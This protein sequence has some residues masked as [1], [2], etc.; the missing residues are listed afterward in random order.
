MAPPPL[1][2]P[3]R[4]SLTGEELLHAVC[5]SSRLA[6]SLNRQELARH[7]VRQPRPPLLHPDP[8]HA[9]YSAADLD[10]LRPRVPAV[11]LLP[12]ER[13]ASTFV[14]FKRKSKRDARSALLF[15]PASNEETHSRVDLSPRQAARAPPPVRRLGRRLAK[16]RSLPAIA[17]RRQRQV[18]LS[19]SSAS[20]ETSASHRVKPALT[21]RSPHRGRVVL[22]R[23]TRPR[24]RLLA[25]PPAP[26]SSVPLQASLS[27]VPGL[28]PWLRF[29]SG[30][31]RIRSTTSVCL[32]HGLVLLPYMISVAGADDTSADDATELKWEFDEELGRYYV[33]FPDDQ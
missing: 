4:T 32:L 11:L 8:H 7:G 23:G 12:G 5:A 14:R 29:R 19:A 28:G 1:L 2:R 20:S 31:V 27:T 3:A 24:P 21:A 6:N 17:G 10:A 22:L 26:R 9:A 30:V 18:P 16:L 13:H 15:H 33:S 25:Q